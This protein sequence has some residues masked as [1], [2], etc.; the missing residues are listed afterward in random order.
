VSSVLELRHIQCLVA[1]PSGPP[2]TVLNDVSLRIERGEQIAIVG[3]SGSG[4][5]SLLAVAGLLDV[6]AKGDVLVDGAVVSHLSDFRRS[7]LRAERFG[8]IFQN[9]SLNRHL[10]SRDNVALPLV[11]RGVS[12]RDRRRESEALLR[13]MGL[14]HKMMEHPRLLSGGEQQRVAIARALVGRPDIIFA[15]EPTSALDTSTG[16]DVFEILR[17][18]SADRG[19]ALV[20]VT[21]DSSL[22]SRVA[23]VVTLCG[24]EIVS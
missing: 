23:R 19:C 24:G 11:Y 6:P 7:A 5:S 12:G 1:Q 10:T 2:L 3:P 20:I 8:F 14:S 9:F 15:D 17:Q 21:H 16:N 22:A 13:R 18:E 4:K